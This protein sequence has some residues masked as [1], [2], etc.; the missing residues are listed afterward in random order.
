MNEDELN[1]DKQKKKKNKRKKYVCKS[2]NYTI[3]MKI[4]PGTIVF[5]L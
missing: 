3:K 4:L 2:T 1:K 5:C